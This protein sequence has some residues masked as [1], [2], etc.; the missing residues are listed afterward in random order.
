MLDIKANQ[1]TIIG[2]ISDM[3]KNFAEVL[4]TLEKIA[5]SVEK[6]N[7]TRS[8]PAFDGHPEKVTCYFTDFVL[9]RFCYFTYYVT[10]EIMLI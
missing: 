3:E 6:T 4:R 7:K 9:Y 1:Q 8:P 5:K 2:E 10:F